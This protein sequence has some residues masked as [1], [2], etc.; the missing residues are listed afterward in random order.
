MPATNFCLDVFRRNDVRGKYL[1]QID[2]EFAERVGQSIAIYARGKK[3]VIGFDARKSSPLITKALAKGLSKQ[4]SET[5]IIGLC[6][7]P[8]LN[9][10][11]NFL[12]AG[13]G[14]MVTASH[15][16]PNFTGF[17]ITKEK[18]IP[19]GE[20]TGL[21]EIKKIFLREEFPK[22]KKALIKKKNVWKDYRKHVLSFLKINKPIKIVID[23]GNSTP[24][25][26]AEKIFKNTKVKAI[27]LN[28]K[29]I[30]NHK[31]SANPL[32]DSN[33]EAIAAVKKHNALLGACFDF[34]GD[35]VMFIDE[36]GK[37]KKSYVVGGIM[38]E[39]LVPIGG[40]VVCDNR[41]DRGFDEM[42]K[43]EGRG[44]IISP[45]GHTKIKLKLRKNDSEFAA[46]F[47]GHFYFK[48]N[49]YTDSGII[50]L[51]KLVSIL[52]KEKKSLSVLSKKYEKY[53]STNELNFNISEKEK[54]ISTISKNFLGG[55]RSVIDG[56]RVDYNDWWFIVRPSQN[57]PL[58]RL[59]VAGKNKKIVDEKRKQIGKIIKSLN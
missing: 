52:N 8:M 20:N 5:I 26:D 30:K 53:Y 58:L 27:V 47:S 40:S 23:G 48:D 28:K 56:L 7:T 38:A 43:Q 46:E 42:L 10:A 15:N 50:A 3:V 34:D 35:R 44:I 12:N 57:E 41:F 32:V 39:A 18:A 25:L 24:A 16:P 55:T 1:E 4:G 17:K 21:D 14:I 31:Y 33:K 2:C 59:I 29:I 22:A 6:S 37:K 54:A 11:C 49:F 9:F 19:L 13:A 45:V 36:K 51:V